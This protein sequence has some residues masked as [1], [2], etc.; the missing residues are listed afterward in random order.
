M[1]PLDARKIPSGFWGAAAMFI[2]L[3]ALSVLL[4]FDDLLLFLVFDNFGGVRVDFSLRLS[5][6][7][8]LTVLNLALAII[9]FSIL[10]KRPE[11]GAEAMIGAKAIVMRA[12]ENEAWVQV[13]GELWRARGPQTLSAGEEVVITGIEGLTLQVQ[14]MPRE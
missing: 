5:A 1:R 13:H 8:V 10:R 6:A 14:K 7:L 3:L 9:A 12:G 2:M 11:T 4:L